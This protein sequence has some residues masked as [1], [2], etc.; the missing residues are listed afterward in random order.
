MLPNRWVC[1]CTF[2]PNVCIVDG[3]TFIAGDD[4]VPRPP[5]DL[6]E[7]ILTKMNRDIQRLV[8]ICGPSLSDN[9][10]Q[11]LEKNAGTNVELMKMRGR[12]S[13]LSVALGAVPVEVQLIKLK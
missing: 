13:A 4:K 1:S 10:K 5:L 11:F 2:A 8:R 9:A 3:E 12:L 7:M 6:M